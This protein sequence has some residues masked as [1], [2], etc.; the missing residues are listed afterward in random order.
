MTARFELS[1]SKSDG[2]I[3][4]PLTSGFDL[5]STSVGVVCVVMVEKKLESWIHCVKMTKKRVVSL[6]FLIDFRERRH[7]ETCLEGR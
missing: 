5:G 4:V 1:L 3:F 7:T 6:T 2:L